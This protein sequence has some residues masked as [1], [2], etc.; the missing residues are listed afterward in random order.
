MSWSAS[1]FWP[2]AGYSG[3]RFWAR[4][5][6]RLNGGGV[7]LR[8]AHHL[9]DKRELV[10]GRGVGGRVHAAAQQLVKRGRA[11]NGHAHVHGGALH[12]VAHHRADADGQRVGVLGAGVAGGEARILAVEVAAGPAR[13]QVTFESEPEVQM[14]V[15]RKCEKLGLG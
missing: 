4:R 5:G 2:A 3:D 7:H 10:A 15:A 9:P 12:A 8:L 6:R 13:G 11:G 1:E 14:S